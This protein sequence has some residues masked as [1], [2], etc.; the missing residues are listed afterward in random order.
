MTDRKL[1]ILAVAAVIMAGWA[2]LQSRVA[3]QAGAHRMALRAPLIQGLDPGAIARISIVSDQAANTVTLVQTNGRFSVVEK[4][5]YPAH[6]S[7]INR[8]LSNCL[9][10]R[11]TEH[12]T[13]NPVNHTDLG[14]TEQT[15][16]SVVRFFNADGQEITGI[17]L[18]ETRPDAEGAYARLT[19]SDETYFV[20]NP[21][22][23]S[24]RPVD[25][26]NTALVEV[27]RDT[28]RRVVVR[29]PEGEY[30]LRKAAAD[31]AIVLEGMP[32]DKQFTGTTYLTVFETLS[33]LRFETVMSAQNAPQ[34]LVFDR[35]YACR[36]ED[37]TVYKLTLAKHEDVTYVT[38]T[39]DFVDT[40]PVQVGRDE[41]P[42]E[43]KK[44][45]A[46]LLAM[47]AARDFAQRHKGWVYTVSSWKADDLTRPLAD[48]LEDKPQSE[49]AQAVVLP[50]ED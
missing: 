32:D 1:A 42:E 12:I 27:D 31:Q 25:Y 15:A 28:I 7:S 34:E 24:T 45:E 22:W 13:S 14:V 33:S 44:K 20:Q 37:T 11:V 36:L 46:K 40:T 49:S 29:G 50:D 26:V 5:H 3:R 17:I 21:P 8:L 10:I 23:F 19:T 39:A 9:D 30:T 41:S 18:S 2:V 48:L 38:I 35:S 4:D 43:L 47:D 6:I 16:R